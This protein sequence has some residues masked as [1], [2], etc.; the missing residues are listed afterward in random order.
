[1]QAKP[2]PGIINGDFE[3]GPEGWT[4]AGATITNSSDVVAHSGEWLAQLT[5]PIPTTVALFTKDPVEWPTQT[6]LYLVFNYHRKL[7]VRY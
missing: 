1:M 4:T 5:L 7:Y 6:P 3:A 2:V